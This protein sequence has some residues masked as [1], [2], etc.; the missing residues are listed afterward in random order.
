MLLSTFS[1]G[2][3]MRHYSFPFSI[4]LPNAI[5]GSFTNDSDNYIRYTIS[6]EL[7]A[8][9]EKSDPQVFSRSLNIR[10]PARIVR[11][12]FRA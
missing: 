4:A 2:I 1:L 8:Y 12:S 6:A 9:D 5:P 10:E 7:P 3:R 11:N